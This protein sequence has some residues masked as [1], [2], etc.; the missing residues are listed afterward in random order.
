MND[1]FKT[2]MIAHPNM[3]QLGSGPEG[4]QK[5]QDHKLTRT[6]PIYVNKC[7]HIA[8]TI[9]TGRGISP[10]VKNK[11]YWYNFLVQPLELQSIPLGLSLRTFVAWGP[12]QKQKIS[13]REKYQRLVLHPFG[14]VSKHIV[15]FFYALEYFDTIFQPWI[16]LSRVLNLLDYFIWLW[17]LSQLQAFKLLWFNIILFERYTRYAPRCDQPQFDVCYATLYI[18]FMFVLE[19]NK[20]GNKTGCFLLK[21]APAAE[22]ISI[23]YVLE[24]RRNKR[25]RRSIPCLEKC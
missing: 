14:D 19:K 20:Y 15:W 4:D 21:K 24:I 11:P 10:E 12:E 5:Y 9:L 6:W 8:D 17:V 25:C 22:H 7:E 23:Y 3:K 2:N 16:C 13:G 18:F 1:A